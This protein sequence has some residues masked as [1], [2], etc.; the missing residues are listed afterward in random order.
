MHTWLPS[1]ESTLKNQECPI[2]A[3]LIYQDTF[4]H[5]KGQKSEILGRRRHW[6]LLKFP[7]W[8]FSSFSRFSVYRWGQKDYLP[9]FYIA[10]DLF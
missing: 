2:L 5:D 1:E 7:Q 8:I 6:I 3:A 4:D 10:D 9:N